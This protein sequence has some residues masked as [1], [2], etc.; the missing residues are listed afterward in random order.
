MK[1]T[2][3]HSI[4]AFESGQPAA[5]GYRDI[6]PQ[7]AFAARDHV[8]LIDVREPN[9]F[10]GELGHVPGS[11][12]VPLSTVASAAES[13]HRDTDIVLICRSG[14]RSRRVAEELVGLG[15][16]RVMNMDGGMLAYH[17]DHLPVERQ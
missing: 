5:G 1:S 6:S 2:I 10:F 17:N 8:R 11:E 9:E 14:A 4:N 13:W 12:L 7:H 16:R 15:F 3:F